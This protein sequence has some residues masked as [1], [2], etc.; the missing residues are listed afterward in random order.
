M[1]FELGVTENQLD[2][3]DILSKSNSS[4]PLGSITWS[5]EYNN[6]MKGFTL[7]EKLLF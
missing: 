7:Q 3:N 6:Q 4:S 2:Q 5:E 1:L